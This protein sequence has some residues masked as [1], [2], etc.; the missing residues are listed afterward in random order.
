MC[1]VKDQLK[2]NGGPNE[3]RQV[4]KEEGGEKEGFVVPPDSSLWRKYECEELC[5]EAEGR[6][7]VCSAFENVEENHDI[8]GK[9]PYGLNPWSF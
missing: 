9:S 4:G 2:V 5:C 3:T 1:N 6:K 7:W 8:G